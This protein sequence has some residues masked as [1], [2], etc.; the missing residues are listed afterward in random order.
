MLRTEIGVLDPAIE[1]PSR[2]GNARW[3][4]EA[5][6]D[7]FVESLANATA[8]HLFRNYSEVRPQSLPIRGGLGG[9]RFKRVCEY[10]E[11]YLDRDLSV[12][13]L[14]DVT[15]LSAHHFGLAFRV[16]AGIPPHR[17]V[18]VRRIERAKR[19]L[20]TTEANVTEIAMAVGFASA[21]H[22]TA[23]FHRLTGATPSRY[24]RDRL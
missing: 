13:E 23:H 24:R 4:A 17:Y 15:G 18:V 10:I 11:T 22:F 20:L 14:A 3:M 1:A 9:W 19:L 5:P 7:D 12:C 8:V 21:S 2:Y 6:E 16:T